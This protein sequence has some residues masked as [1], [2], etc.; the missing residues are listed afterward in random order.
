MADR[1]TVKK[2]EITCGQCIH[3]HACSMQC[4]GRP[5]KQDNALGCACFEDLKSS[6]AY[7][8]GTLDGA[9]GKIPPR[10]R[11]LVEA[12]KEC[13]TLILPCQG[14][15]D[16]IL[17]RNGMTFKPDH[18]NFHLTAFAQNQSVPSGMQ[19]GLFDI[20]EVQKALGT[21]YD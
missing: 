1:K 3:E 12:D 4:S 15:A 13:R 11:E 18:W 19:V 21:H 16:I 10:V 6:T 17:I 8:I 20:K 14:D 7:F 2:I 5:M 9:K